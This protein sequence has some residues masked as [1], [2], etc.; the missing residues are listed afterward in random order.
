MLLVQMNFLYWLSLKESSIKEI[1]EINSKEFSWL[2][3][4]AFADANG[5]KKVKF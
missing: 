3:F 5:R 1:R 4:L 2:S